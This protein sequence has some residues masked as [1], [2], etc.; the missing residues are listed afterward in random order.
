MTEQKFI[1]G[2][3]KTAEVGDIVKVHGNEYEIKRIIMQDYYGEKDET[4]PNKDWGFF[5]EFKDADDKYHYWKQYQ[6]GGEIISGDK[7]LNMKWNDYCTTFHTDTLY[8]TNTDKNKLIK[9]S[10]GTG[11]NLLPE[12]EEE[13]YVDYWHCDV[14]TNDGQ[15]GGGIFYLT[16]LI[17]EKNLSIKDTIKFL[18]ENEDMF[19][20][21][22]L[23][24]CH[25]ISVAEGEE[26][27]EHF[28]EIEDAMYNKRKQ[29]FEDGYSDLE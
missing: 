20:E 2:T 26:L 25:L 8:F 28:E 14:Y 5:M 21:V 27:E 23:E 15:I 10:E 18:T 3:V 11:D 9:V 6:D 1:F 17:A 13:G 29:D 16:E 24:N 19:D 12:D 7:D 4:N 22:D